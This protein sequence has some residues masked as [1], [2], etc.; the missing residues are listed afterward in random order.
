MLR[1]G[2]KADA[3]TASSKQV[4]F[5]GETNKSGSQPEL[6]RDETFGGSKLQV[7]Q[8]DTINERAPSG[9]FAEYAEESPPHDQ[10]QVAVQLPGPS[11]D[12]ESRPEVMLHQESKTESAA[13]SE[14]PWDKYGKKQRSRRDLFSKPLLDD[15][16]EVKPLDRII[17]SKAKRA[18]EQSSPSKASS[19]AT[20][21]SEIKIDPSN[22]S[23][24]RNVLSQENAK[25]AGKRSKV[26]A[27]QVVEFDLHDD[28]ADFLTKHSAQ[29]G[30]Q[31]E[32]TPIN[33]PN[34]AYENC[35]SSGIRDS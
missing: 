34:S 19:Q 15:E 16:E 12:E 9:D 24:R 2:S 10:R 7:A 18:P 27:R 14:N 26:P 1:G 23:Q 33:E 32:K 5:E 31:T 22:I 13:K 20:Q 11:Y 3:Q 35:F 29:S 21:F 28:E 17:R 8:P 4:T 30:K 25:Q 6:L